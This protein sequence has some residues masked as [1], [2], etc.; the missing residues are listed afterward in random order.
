[1]VPD[2]VEGRCFGRGE[3][4]H[5]SHG[6]PPLGRDIRDVAARDDLHADS[7][8]SDLSP[9]RGYDG[10]EDHRRLMSGTMEGRGRPKAHV[11]GEAQMFHELRH[12]LLG[13]HAAQR[14]VLR[15]N[16]QEEATERHRDLV[17]LAQ[18]TADLAV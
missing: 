13:R 4:K 5:A 3:T 9:V 7:A 17:L 14:P 10:L 2:E 6:I 15:R 12:E 8:A 11:V 16:H 1:M 18:P